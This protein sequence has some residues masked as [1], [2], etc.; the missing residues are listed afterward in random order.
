MKSNKIEPV[1]NGYTIGTHTRG[2]ERKAIFSEEDFLSIMDSL[3]NTDE[4]SEFSVSI[5][6]RSN[7][8]NKEVV[9]KTNHNEIISLHNQL[10]FSGFRSIDINQTISNGIIQLMSLI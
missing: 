10:T 7:K 1:R 8:D 2:G 3:N 6:I 9:L 4:E 5:I